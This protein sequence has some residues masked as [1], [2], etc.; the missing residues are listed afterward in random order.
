[1]LC[2]VEKTAEKR[3]EN[4]QMNGL[5]EN[6]IVTVNGTVTKEATYSHTVYG[7]GFYTFQI[8]SARLSSYADILPV[9]VSERLLALSEKKLQEGSQVCITGQLRS[10]NHFN[11]EKNRLMLTVFA[12]ELSFAEKDIA[13]PANEI[14]LHGYICKKPVYRQTPFGREISDILVAVNR[15]YHKSDYIP[16]IVWGRNARYVGEAAVGTPISL[17]GRIQSRIYQK[18]TG[19]IMEERIAYEVS[20]SQMELEGKVE[21]KEK[22]DTKD[23]REERN[24][25]MF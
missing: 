15:A 2:F 6:N 19:D 18:K 9:M 24:F 5:W 11:G 21:T 4:M 13:E 17:K 16:C 25:P 14:L 7:E 10:Y 3:G 23:H 12:R 20:V 1:M 22:S 8:A